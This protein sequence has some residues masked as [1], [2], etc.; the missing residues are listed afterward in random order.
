MIVHAAICRIAYD[1]DTTEEFYTQYNPETQILDIDIPDEKLDLLMRAEVGPKLD[2]Y[3][4]WLTSGI[5]NLRRDTMQ[6]TI[7]SSTSLAIGQQGIGLTVGYDCQIERADLFLA[8]AG[9]LELELRAVPADDWPGDS[10]HILGSVSVSNSFSS[11]DANIQG[12][13]LELRRGDVIVY[14]VTNVG[15]AG[16]QLATLTLYVCKYVTFESTQI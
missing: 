15:T 9:D 4:A 6:F 14:R 5:A 11:V 1:D 10:S 8:A 13:D 2:R 12:W 7:G 3:F 16:V